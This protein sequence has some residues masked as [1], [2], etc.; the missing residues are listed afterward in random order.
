MCTRYVH[1]ISAHYYTTRVH[2]GHPLDT[3]TRRTHYIQT[4]THHVHQP[5]HVVEIY[6]GIVDIFWQLKYFFISRWYY[7]SG[8]VLKTRILFIYIYTYFYCPLNVT[9]KQKLHS[10]TYFVVNNCTKGK[11]RTENCFKKKKLS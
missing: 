11:N 8:N 6:G 2:S 3:C 1:V 4:N 10:S 5:Y 9:I 7:S